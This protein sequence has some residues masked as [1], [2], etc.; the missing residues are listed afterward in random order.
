MTLLHFL[1]NPNWHSYPN[2]GRPRS[3]FRPNINCGWINCLSSELQ[4]RPSLFFCRL[5][6]ARNAD[7]C[8]ALSS[9][10]AVVWVVWVESRWRCGNTALTICPVDGLRFRRKDRCSTKWRQW[11]YWWKLSTSSRKTG[12]ASRWIILNTSLI[13]W[14]GKWTVIENGGCTWHIEKRIHWLLNATGT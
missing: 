11:T 4:N 12:S 9:R 6:A 3:P 2:N 1:I 8:C 5:P 13:G 10:E 14:S 7:A